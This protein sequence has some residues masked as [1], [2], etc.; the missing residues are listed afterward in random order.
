MDVT[1]TRECLGRSDSGGGCR[2]PHTSTLTFLG[3]NWLCL[4]SYDPLARTHNTHPG[5]GASKTGS[6]FFR[7]GISLPL[8]WEVGPTGCHLHRESNLA[9]LF[10]PG[11]FVCLR[12]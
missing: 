12:I 9:A 10:I 4:S 3:P 2:V 6:L 8:S 7:S 11:D 5:P 1:T